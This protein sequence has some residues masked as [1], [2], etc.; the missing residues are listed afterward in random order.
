MAEQETSLY[1]VV[2]LNDDKTP[3]EFVVRVLQN[4]FA[5]DWE[6]AKQK[7]FFIHRYGAGECGRYDFE[8]A[9]EKAAA[10]V[11]FARQHNHPLECTIEKVSLG[12]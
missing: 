1:S 3:M 10:I 6:T 7:M 2:L 8:L 5:M 9:K 4:Y 11:A 12:T